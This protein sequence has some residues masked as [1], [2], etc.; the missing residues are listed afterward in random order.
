[1]AAESLKTYDPLQI[2]I[3]FK[4]IEFKGFKKGTFVKVSR[5]TPL[6][7]VQEGSDGFV[8]RVRSRSKLGTM[9]VT[10]V[11]AS[12]TNKQLSDVVRSDAA[13]GD[14]VAPASVRDLN[15]LDKYI[16]E[17]AFILN[18]ADGEFAEDA[19]ERMWKFQLTNLDM[20]SGGA[21]I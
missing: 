3:I 7:S 21:T 18:P 4:G 1:M 19:G 8:T 12:P 15:G 6:W 14:G 9:E 17:A 20:F 16:S 13:N 10:L 5:S 11:A 2:K